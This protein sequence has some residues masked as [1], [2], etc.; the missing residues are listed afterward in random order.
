M[1]PYDAA[2]RYA[3]GDYVFGSR[4]AGGLPD[5]TGRDRA[6]RDRDIVVWV[7]LGMHHI[8]RAEDM[9]VMPVVWHAFRP[10]PND[11]FGR[12]P[13]AGTQGEE[14]AMK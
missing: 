13:A 4:D 2:E 8:P 5:W 6:I 1:T 12:N 7:N 10:R 9:P 14:R 11:F 3:A